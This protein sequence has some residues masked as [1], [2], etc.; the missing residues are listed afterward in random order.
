MDLANWRQRY[1]RQKIIVITCNI[2]LRPLSDNEKIQ[3]LQLLEEY[4]N[5]ECGDPE[6]L[7]FLCGDAVHVMDDP[8]FS[9]LNAR[10]ER[11]QFHPPNSSWRRWRFSIQRLFDAD[12]PPPTGSD[13][14][15]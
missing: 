5:F 1:S 11:I 4:P 9:S 14:E 2:R 6:R 12:H 3:V 8:G 7:C 10:L 13:D 15:I